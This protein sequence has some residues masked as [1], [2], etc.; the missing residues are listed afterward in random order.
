MPDGGLFPEVI[1]TERLRL[2]RLDEALTVLEQYEHV[3]AGAPNV[4]E[5]TE[6]MTWDPHETP[7]ETREFL[8]GVTE[9]WENGERAEYAVVPRDG[10]PRAG[11]YAGSAGMGIDWDRR[12]GTLGMWLRK[13]FWGRGYSGERAAAHMHLAFDRLDLEMVAVTHEVGND[14]SRRAIEKYVDRFG[15]RREGA[16]RNFETHLDSGPVD[17]VRYTVSRDEWVANRPDDPAVEF[18]DGT[19]H[20]ESRGTNP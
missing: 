20:A 4:D 11:E 5:V 13:P 6:Y 17:S 1:E 19:D 15:G 16:F 12:T 9:G 8:Q 2:E 7:D 18:L 10:E 3:S 14:K